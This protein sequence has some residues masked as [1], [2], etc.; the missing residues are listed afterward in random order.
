MINGTYRVVAIGDLSP[1]PQNPNRQSKFV[2]RK[3]V[4]SIREFG[5]TDPIIARRYKKGLQIIGGEH[6]WRVAQEMGMAEV[7]VIDIG[8][9]ADHVANRLSIVL[10]ETRGQPDQD[11]LSLLI[12][13]IRDEGGDASLAVLPYSDAAL[14]D[15]LDE[16]VVHVDDT[17]PPPLDGP[18]KLKAID[19]L[20]ALELSPSDQQG[21]QAFIDGVR[22]WSRTRAPDAPTAWR[23]VLTR[24]ALV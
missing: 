15:L 2:H 10:N 9:V 18:V 24:L 11:A 14:A 23:D 7:P 12:Q 19:V 1:N 5:F 4:E 16:E 22:A 17:P 20:S 8:V 6:R 21:I 13:S 3:L